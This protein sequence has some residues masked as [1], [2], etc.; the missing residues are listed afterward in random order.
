VP[1]LNPQ[2]KSLICPASSLSKWEIEELEGGGVLQCFWFEVVA[3]DERMEMVNFLVKRWRLPLRDERASA[4]L[5]GNSVRKGGIDLIG[6]DQH[7]S[8]QD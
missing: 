4:P 8:K 2:A 3:N 7:Q 5:L 6:Q 1:T